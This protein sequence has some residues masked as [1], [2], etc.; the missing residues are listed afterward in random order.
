MAVH[1]IDPSE[2]LPPTHGEYEDAFTLGV[3]ETLI[4][5]AGA[6]IAAYG[7]GSMGISGLY[8]NTLLIDGR[9]HSEFSS[10]IM[11][12]GIVIVGATGSITGA[13]DGVYLYGQT[14][15]SNPNILING[16]LVS[17]GLNGARF[18]GAESI[19]TNSGTIVGGL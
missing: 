7:E 10:A 15:P 13:V 4:L 3:D 5:K 17:G 8:G 9:V 14:A 16:G 19:I 2:P 12:Q 6:E 1:I 18:E 11:I